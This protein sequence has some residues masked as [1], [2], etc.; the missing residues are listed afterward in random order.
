MDLVLEPATVDDAPEVFALKKAIAE[1]LTEQFGKGNWSSY[2][3]ED[4]VA[5]SIESPTLWLCR[6]AGELIAMLRLSTRKPWAID[7]AYFT[8]V[9]QPLYLTDMAVLPAL[10]RQGVGR[11]LL[12]EA[13]RTARA[14]KGDAIRLDAYEGPAGAG[15]FY[16]RCGYREVG[17]VTYRRVRLVYLERLL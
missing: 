3:S 9:E 7:P 1:H 2:G 13:E 11:R 17:R 8:R 14:W 6:D 4:G 5:R 16:A 10:Q 12:A 15:V